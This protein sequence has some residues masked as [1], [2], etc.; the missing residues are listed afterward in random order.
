MRDTLPSASRP[1]NTVWFLPA[2]P[3]SCTQNREFMSKL[4]AKSATSQPMY[5]P[6]LLERTLLSTGQNSEK[7]C[8][9]NVTAYTIPN[10]SLRL[11]LDHLW[12]APTDVVLFSTYRLEA[13]LRT[14]SVLRSLPTKLD[15]KHFLLHFQRFLLLSELSVLS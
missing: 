1:A 9:N 13:L 14:Q 12:P 15:C 8:A 5:T 6:V 11:F 4:F 10:Q 3:S 2:Q 7:T